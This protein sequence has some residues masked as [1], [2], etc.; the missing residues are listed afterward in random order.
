[1]ESQRSLLFIAL[2]VV[3]YLLFSQWQL[4]NAPETQQTSINQQQANLPAPTQNDEAE[5]KKGLFDFE[6]VARNVLNFVGGAIKNAQGKGADDEALLSLFE[7]AT[8]GVL[9]GIDLAKKDLA[10]ISNEEIRYA[11]AHFFTFTDEQYFSSTT[12]AVMG[13]LMRQRYDSNPPCN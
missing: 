12:N 4:Q 5:P 7:Q 9:K 13:S 1:M 8:S 11:S 6:E 3:T 2:M 10:G